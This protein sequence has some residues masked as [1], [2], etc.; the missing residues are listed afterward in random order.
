MRERVA[1]HGGEFTAG[2]RPDGGWQVAAVLPISS[3]ARAGTVPT[4]VTS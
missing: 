1:V 4:E 3:P 2:P